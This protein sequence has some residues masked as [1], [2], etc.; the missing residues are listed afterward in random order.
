MH[1]CATGQIPH[2]GACDLQMTAPSSILAAAHTYGSLFGIVTG[3]IQAIAISTYL[4]DGL[5]LESETFNLITDYQRTTY[6]AALTA[7]TTF[8]GVLNTVNIKKLLESNFIGHGIKTTDR[9]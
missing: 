3:F 9:I 1:A 7:L 2:L 6:I 4:Y 5:I 8:F